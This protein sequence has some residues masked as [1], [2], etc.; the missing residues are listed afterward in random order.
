VPSPV[1]MCDPRILTPEMAR[2]PAESS[3]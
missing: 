2:T 3:N 1:V